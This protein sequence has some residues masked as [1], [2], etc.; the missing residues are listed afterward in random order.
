LVPPRT[1][2]KSPLVKMM[3]RAGGAGDL[4][5][6][7][8]IGIAGLAIG[9]RRVV[10]EGELIAAAGFDVRV[11]REVAGVEFAAGEPA[12]A[13]VLVLAQDGLGRLEPIE[14]LRLPTRELL[15][16]LDRGPILFSIAHALLHS[17]SSFLSPRTEAAAP[18]L[19]SAW[20]RGHQRF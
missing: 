9:D 17:H 19:L 12:V 4:V 20:R 14:L 15:G 18:I 1:P 2:V 11:E 13:A 3:Q 10:D 6:Q 8:V 7:F 5:A 16:I